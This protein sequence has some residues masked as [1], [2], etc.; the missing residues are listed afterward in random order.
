[1]TGV[2]PLSFVQGQ[3]YAPEWDGTLSIT[4]LAL[5]MTVNALVTG[6]IVFRILKVFR[7][8]ETTVDDHIL[9]DTGRITLWKIIFILIESGIVL[10][11]VQLARLL[12]LLPNVASIASID[13]FQLIFP[14][15]EML[16]VIIRSVIFSLV[17][18]LLM[19]LVGPC[20]GYYT[21]NHLGTGI[22]GIVFPR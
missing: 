20:I 4:G 12:V 14:L 21:Y 6:L 11:S 5:S 13:A 10:F 17:I 2:A 15:H 8:V 1:M 3:L 9:G 19:T 22:N 18:I 16:N 7:A